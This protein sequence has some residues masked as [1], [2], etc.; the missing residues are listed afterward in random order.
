MLGRGVQLAEVL[1]HLVGG[2]RAVDADQ[3]VGAPLGGNLGERGLEHR[4]VIGGG[5]RAGIARALHHR[6]RIADVGAPAG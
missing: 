3:H 4:E 1:D 2:A 5:E 6:Q